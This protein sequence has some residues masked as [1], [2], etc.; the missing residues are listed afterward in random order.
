MEDAIILMILGVTAILIIL[1]SGGC[2]YIVQRSKA[3]WTTD[4]SK[5]EQFEDR[6][7]AIES[8]LGDIQ[9][10]VISIDDQ[11]KRSSQN[12]ATPTVSDLS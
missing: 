10:V 11:L 8:R 7:Q 12:Q 1:A 6:I 5:I 4:T 2:Y 9:E 3:K